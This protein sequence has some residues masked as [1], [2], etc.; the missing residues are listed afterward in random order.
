MKLDKSEQY[1]QELL[2]RRRRV[3]SSANILFY[4]SAKAELLIERAEG[5]Y[6]IDEK[7]T[8]YLD[9][10][11]NVAHVGHCH[12]AVTAAVT[13]QMS[14]QYT[15]TRYLNPVIVNY[16]EALLSHFDASLD[17]VLFCNSGS[18]ATDLALRLAKYYTDKTDYICLEAAY[19]GHVQNALDVSPYKWKENGCV[20]KPDHVHVVDAPDAFRGKFTDK[21][22]GQ[23]YADQVKVVLE[24]NAGKV[25]GFIAESLM[26]CAGQVIPPNN[27][28]KEVYKHCREH[29]TLC[30]ADEVQVGFGRTGRHMWAYELGGVTPDIVTLGKP[31]GNGFPLSAVVTRREIAD[32]YWKTGSQYFNT[33]GGN[34]IAISAA[35]AVLNVIKDEKLMENAIDV[36]DYLLAGF[37][38]LKEKYPIISDVR[39]HGLFL[40]IELMKNGVPNSKDTY[41]IRNA[42]LDQHII[43]PVDGPDENILKIKSPMCLTRSNADAILSKM[44]TVLEQL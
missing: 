22:A 9:L 33:F 27:Y 17:T 11:N 4:E 5:Q 23:K 29:G 31:I 20:Q 10:S 12:P 39:G 35:H 8:K 30:I 40:G 16:S 25:A 3:L 43:M 7:G 32:S 28:F 36:G 41:K 24:Q 34:A 38:R 44:E 19:H 13:K 15:N 1:K 2:Q 14:L 42:L 21:M 37:K 18:E 6:L 26:S